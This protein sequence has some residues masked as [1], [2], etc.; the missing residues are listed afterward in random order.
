MSLPA[1][2]YF[3]ASHL[4]PK[5]RKFIEDYTGL[6]PEQT[7]RHILEVVR[8]LLSISYPICLLNCDRTTVE[9]SSLEHLA[10]PVH[11]RFPLPGAWH[12]RLIGVP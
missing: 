3:D 8:S 6:S 10:V 5:A 4:S 11:R 12:L 7:E 2:G 9:R 1:D